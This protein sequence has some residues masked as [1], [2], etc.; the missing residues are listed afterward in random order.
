MHKLKHKLVSRFYDWLYR[1]STHGRGSPQD[2]GIS[3]PEFHGYGST[4]SY[5][6]LR[7]AIRA[8]PLAPD[9]ISFLDLGSGKGR[10]LVVA[11]MLGCK[12]VHGVEI[13]EPVAEVARS[14][15]ARMRWRRTHET[16]VTIADATH[17]QIPAQVN[18]VYIANSFG[19]ETL[20]RVLEN[21]RRS[22]AKYLLYFNCAALERH[23]SPPPPPACMAEAHRD[24]YLLPSIRLGPVRDSSR[25]YCQ[26][27]RSLNEHA[28]QVV[29]GCS[30]S[31]RHGCTVRTKISSSRGVRRSRLLKLFQPPTNTLR[32]TC[33]AMA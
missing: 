18:V 20:S 7:Q 29:V 17:F 23:T 10:P 11:S 15:L 28:P 24:R 9:E 14:N 22:S 27:S 4:I 25:R 32:A 26:S 30:G 3:N 8:V 12:A 13:V 21:I 1:V 33:A 2:V 6:A 5:R 31:G 16:S 19:G